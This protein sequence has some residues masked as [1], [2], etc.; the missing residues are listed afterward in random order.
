M[1][2]CVIAGGP[3]APPWRA[4]KWASKLSL[5]LRASIPDLSHKKEVKA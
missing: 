4:R 5:A 3:A 1:K 2:I